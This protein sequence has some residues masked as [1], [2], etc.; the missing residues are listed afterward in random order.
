M[1]TGTFDD[2]LERG[3]SLSESYRIHLEAT[4]NL[5]AAK[6]SLHRAQGE[7][8]SAIAFQKNTG[9]AYEDA[10]VALIGSVEAL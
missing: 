1:N 10:K 9:K 3:E 5:E 4:K 7:L 6:E 2:V 8:E